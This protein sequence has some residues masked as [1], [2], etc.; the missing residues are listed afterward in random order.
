MTELEN[1]VISKKLKLDTTQT[2]SDLEDVSSEE[3]ELVD[4]TAAIYV[5]DKTLRDCARKLKVF[6]TKW[7]VLNTCTDH[8]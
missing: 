7:F 5:L 2:P 4:T 8:H 6:L 3:I 1:G